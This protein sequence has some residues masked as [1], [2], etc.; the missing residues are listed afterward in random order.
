MQR[1]RTNTSNST[2]PMATT[3]DSDRRPR[4][5]NVRYDWEGEQRERCFR[6]IEGDLSP[7]EC[8]PNKP[9]PGLGDAVASATKAVGI[10]PCAPCAKRQ[11]AL[12]RATPGWLS[13]IL[14]RSSQLVD[15]LKARVWKR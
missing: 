12:N 14:L 13:R 5:L 15:R 10:K 7:C 4:R 1:G 3:S 9:A 2:N 6:I 11:A 8:S